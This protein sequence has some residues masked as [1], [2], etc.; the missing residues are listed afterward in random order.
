MNKSVEIKKNTSLLFIVNI[1]TLITLILFKVY[2]TSKGYYPILVNVMLAINVVALLIG[3]TFNVLFVKNPNKYE[4]SFCVKVVISCF[5]FYLLINT[6]GVLL[7]NKPIDKQ[8]SKTSTK[9]WG[10]CS[11][12][13][14][15]RYETVKNGRYEEFV[16][17]KTYFDYNRNENALEIRTKYDTKGVV[18][19]TATVYS[20]KEM[21]AE[22]LIRDQLT[23]YYSYFN[24]DVSSDKIREAFNKRFESS[25][26]DG[27][28]SYQVKEIYNNNELENLKTIVTLDLKKQD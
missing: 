28:A 8:F 10:Y 16:I 6:L 11:T 22:A 27:K 26:G 7:I 9:L 13:G 25:V 4:E 2:F 23:G 1:I 15:D 18:S 24:Y 3:I 12:F 14:C 21:F 5:I 20:R 19:V 17:K